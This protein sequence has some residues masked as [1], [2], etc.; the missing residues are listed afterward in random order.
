MLRAVASFVHAGRA[1]AIVACCVPVV[2]SLGSFHDT[3]SALLADGRICPNAG[4]ANFEL[5]RA[6]AAVPACGVPVVA[7]FSGGHRAVPANKADARFADTRVRR[8]DSA[9]RAS[10]VP[11]Y[12]TAVVSGF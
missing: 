12:C 4:P 9:C 11:A 3:V 5:A 1:A 6:A 8:F 2:T 7:L 10:A